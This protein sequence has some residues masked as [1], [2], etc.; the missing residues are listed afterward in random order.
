MGNDKL[1]VYT[2]S[3][4]VTA[5]VRVQKSAMLGHPARSRRSEVPGLRQSSV[6]PAQDN[7]AGVRRAS[8]K[9]RKKK[10]TYTP[11]SPHIR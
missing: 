10:S 3:F 6:L 1:S 5:D 9:A 11:A 2:G 8:G 7:S 4:A